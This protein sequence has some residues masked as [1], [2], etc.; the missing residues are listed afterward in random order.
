MNKKILYLTYDGLTDPLGQSQILP[1]LVKLSNSYSYTIISFEKKENTYLIKKIKDIVK[2]HGIKWIPLKYTKKPPIISTIIDLL[3]LQFIA[4]RL[5]PSQKISLIHCRGSYI[6]SLVGLKMKLKYNVKY[7]FDMRGFWADER[8]DG[9]IWN[10]NNIVHK[11][12]YKFFKKKEVKFLQK[13]DY[14]ISLTKSGKKEIESWK[15]P[16]L[17][18][19]KVIPCCTD[20]KLFQKKNTFNVRDKLGLNKKDFILSYI[21]SI[22]TWYMLEEMLD[23][24]LSLNEKIPDAKFLFITK[25]SKKV[26]FRKA[27]KKGIPKEKILVASSTREMMPSYISACNLSIFFIKP[28]FSKKASSP[29]KMGEIMNLGVP[30]VCNKGIGDVDD[31]MSKCMPELLVNNFSNEEYKRVT[32]VFL[33]KKYENTKIIEISN[34]YY[35]LE[36]GVHKYKEIYQQVLFNI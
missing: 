30:I 35:S 4:M 31:I 21:G 3:K 17:S 10:L 33:I 16:N 15:I 12:M 19:I 1:Y 23:F 6:T 18:P 25:D 14:T 2:S 20:L 36:S 8:I 7:I 22:G 34:N 27:N 13:S 9:N 11:K 32:E 28:L 29:T 26:I 5:V 24:F